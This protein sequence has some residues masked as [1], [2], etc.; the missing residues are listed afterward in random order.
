MPLRK[1]PLVN[2]EVYHLF[3]RG[4]ERRPVFTT[5][6]DYRRFLKTIDFYRF[7]TP[8]FKLS[9]F[10]DSS[11]QTREEVLKKLVDEKRELVEIYCFCLMP[12]HFHFLLRQLKNGGISSFLRLVQNSYAKYYNIKRNRV[13]SLFQG[14]FKAV[15]V[16]TDKQLLHLSRYIHLN[17]YTSH[18]IKTVKELKAYRWS[19]LLDYLGG[20][21]YSFLKRELILGFFKNE[22][23]YQKFV[24]DRAD[25]QRRL[26]DINH[27]IWDDQ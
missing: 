16:E 26:G 21:N 9:R 5:V 12:N 6:Y 27:L 13:G 25:Y 3:N 2:N 22:R 19:S 8:P 20:D 11:R 15:R 23:D 10:F 24:F 4:I 7:L 18:V 14:P 1:I 17:P